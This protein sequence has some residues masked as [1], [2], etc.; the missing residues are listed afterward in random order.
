MRKLILASLTISSTLA[1]QAP[2]GPPRT[3]P[4][5]G[6]LERRLAQL[7][8]VPPFDRATWGDRK[9]GVE[10]KRVDLGGRR[11]IKKKKN[12][13]LKKL[14]LTWKTQDEDQEDVER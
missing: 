2:G 3:T 6:S 14:A 13:N 8:D 10:G 12:N 4:L 9:G 7:L 1:A 11:I 5:R